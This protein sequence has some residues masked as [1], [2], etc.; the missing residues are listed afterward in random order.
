MLLFDPVTTLLAVLIALVLDRL[1]GDP[2]WLWARLPHPA[3]ALGGLIAWLE[4]R[5]LRTDAAPARKAL[6]GAGALA[7]VVGL[8]ASI[9]LGLAALLE[10][11][12]GTA[13]W[14]GLLMSALI[15]HRSLDQHVRA[16]ADALDLGLRDGREAVRHIVGRD[17]ESLDRGAVARASIE[18]AA[19]NFSDGV[20][21]PALWA[22][23]LGLP[24]I[25][26]YKAINTADSMIGHRSDRYLHFGR[27]AARLDDLVNWPAARLAGLLIV[28]SAGQRRRAAFDAM[29]RDAAKHRSPNAGW[30][31]AAMAGA[32]DLRLAGPRAY[33]GTRIEDAWMGTGRGD[34][35]P[36]DIRRALALIG[37]A[38]WLM[39]VPLVLL[40]VSI[41]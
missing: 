39:T 14:L 34:A 31:E 26:A 5:L 41:L 27:V 32:L 17:P 8:A 19:E 16:V 36:S 9:G 15:A 23:L 35:T 12:P 33:A 10:E 29:V 6:S 1:I 25:V 22:L 11:L 24:G 3:A 21:A 2:P 18:S 30:P 40:A 28:L 38:W 4:R 7:L 20:V 13:L 37:R